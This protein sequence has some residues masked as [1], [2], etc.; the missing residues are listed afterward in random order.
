MSRPPIQFSLPKMNKPPPI[1]EYSHSNQTKGGIVPIENTLNRQTKIK[2]GGK[3][4][5][6]R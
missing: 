1:L 4:P 6:E 3:L 5:F 2:V